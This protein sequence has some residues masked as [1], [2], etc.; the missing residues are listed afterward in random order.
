[1]AI[2]NK[3]RIFIKIITTMKSHKL[4]NKDALKFIFAGK[5]IV[6]FLNTK[7]QNRFTFKVKGAKDS[8]LFFVS[9]LTN[10]ETYTYIGT[11]IEGQFKWGKKSP[12]SSDS[13]SVKVFEY[14]LK[15][16]VVGNL[17]DF[18]EIWHEGHC[19]KCG[20]RLTVP[21]SIINGLGPECIK[22]LSK[23]EKRD[24]FL[25]MILS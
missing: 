14:I 19:G 24:K 13:Q 6:T 3:C 18:I 11:C 16:L 10:P 5:A 17:P 21:A 22:T 12:I 25:E 1:M 7:T 9:V 15:R 23:K 4:D 20:K 2:Y 8:N